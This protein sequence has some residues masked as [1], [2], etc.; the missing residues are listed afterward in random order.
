MWS[1]PP[2]SVRREEAGGSVQ[3]R[4]LVHDDNGVPLCSKVYPSP[5]DASAAQQELADFLRGLEGELLLRALDHWMKFGI[6][7]RAAAPWWSAG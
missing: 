7:S 1:C 6:A 2:L 3:W 4:L 5:E